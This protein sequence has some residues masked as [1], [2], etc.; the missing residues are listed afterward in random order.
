MTR[1]RQDKQRHSMVD[2]QIAARGI[3]DRRVL[4][5]MR[6]VPR[7]AF[8]PDHVR[9]LAY[10]DQALPIEAGQTISQPYIV[11]RMAALAEIGPSDRVLEIGA[12]SGYAAA[13]LGKMA[14]HVVGIERHRELAD[15]ARARMAA[16][17]YGNVDIVCGDGFGGQPAAAPF[18]A[19]IVSAGAD[20]MPPALKQQLKIGGRLVIPLSHGDHQVLVRVRRTGEDSYVEEQHEP[21]AFVPLVA[22]GT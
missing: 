5:A 9:Q 21:V 16:L 3:S 22:G 18:D 17:G 8:V 6:E 2:R 15:L 13:V 19:I 4:D 14:S 20:T 11:A 1:S 10:T 12:G 7:H